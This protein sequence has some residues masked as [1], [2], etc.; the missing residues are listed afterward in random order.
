MTND[1]VKFSHPKGSGNPHSLSNGG[2]NILREEVSLPCAVLYESRLNNNIQWMQQFAD[3]AKVKLAPH[4]KTSMTPEL[5]QAQ[6]AQGAWAMTLATVPQ[7]VT[8]AENGIKRIIMAN[9]LVGKTH[10][11]WI[12]TMLRDTEV[13]FYCLVD[14]VENIHQLGQFFADSG[15][16]LQLLL[17]VG[18][19]GG[20]CGCRDQATLQQL[21]D[22]VAGYPALA[23]C[24]IEFYEGVIHGDNAES[25]VREFIQQVVNW[26]EQLI[27]QD[28]FQHNDVII[29]GA[30]SAWYDVVA[31][32]LTQQSN[33]QRLVPV[34]RPGCYAIHDT[35]IYED[36]QNQIMARS[37][38]AC[39]VGG[40]LSS[41]LELWAYVLSV[42]EPGRAIVGL[43]KRDVAFDAGLPTPVLFY[44]P[45][46]DA[47][48]AADSRWTVT[49]IMDQH[50][51][52]ETT[53]DADL[54]PGDIISFSTSH[55][56]LT[57]DKWRH[58]ALADDEFC[59][60]RTLATCF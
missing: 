47:P 35:G 57:M 2:W 23:L 41:S 56:C 4:G 40:D 37:R 38:L 24:G 34:I 48:V 5:F 17:E 42:P 10:F 31:E 21:A 18:V 25:H 50:A 30:G 52:L 1:P 60:H 46:D 7:V 26:T 51:A 58:V 9:Q 36:A 12:L 14:S 55:P 20:R 27:E 43:G 33:H 11:E 49:N 3:N 32:E 6:Q 59:I 19:P 13:D 54:K 39:D 44:R 15:V 16:K 22:T 8:A 45:G 28:R 53:P 29:T